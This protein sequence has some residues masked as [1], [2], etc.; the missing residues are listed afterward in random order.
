MAIAGANGQ[1]D[2]V[3]WVFSVSIKLRVNLYAKYNMLA[4]ITINTGFKIVD[5]KFLKT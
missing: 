4:K 2:G 5:E 1:Y 3:C